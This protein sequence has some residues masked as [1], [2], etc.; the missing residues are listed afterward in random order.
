VPL[1]INTLSETDWQLAG[2][3]Q[4]GLYDLARYM[5]PPTGMD[6]AEQ[7]GLA[8]KLNGTIKTHVGYA[9]AGTC[10]SPDASAK[11]QRV[12]HLRG[13]SPVKLAQVIARGTAVPIT[14]G[15]ETTQVKLPKSAAPMIAAVNG[16]RDLAA[17]AQVA[18]LDPIAARSIWAQVE[19]GLLPWGMLLYS[20]LLKWA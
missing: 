4:Q 7:M 20:N 5:I 10:V 1:L 17:I 15:A 18:K 11:N 12:P 19:T 9:A 8:E 2:F 3:C 13:V 6:A 14:I 16:Q